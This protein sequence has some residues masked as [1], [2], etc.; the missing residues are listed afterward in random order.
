MIQKNLGKWALDELSEYG[1]VGGVA[2]LLGGI[3]FGIWMAEKGAL[4]AIASMVG[5]NSIMLGWA[6]HLGIS[7][8][9]GVSFEVLFSHLIEGVISSSLWGI[10]Y[11]FVW[12]F[13]GPMTLMPL[14]MG[15][16]L[17]WTASAVAGT[18][19][20]LIWH[21]VF[22]GIMGISYAAMVLE[23]FTFDRSA[24]AEL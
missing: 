17:Q 13:L 5:G 10:V 21:L 6:M 7:I 9:I 4:T 11:G 8:G 2:G 19:P 18:I 1:F 3:V 24:Q 22:G 14:M 23:R 15:M 12:W 16:P 20:S